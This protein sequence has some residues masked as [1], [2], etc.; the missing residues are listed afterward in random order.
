[1]KLHRH[2]IHHRVP[3]NIKSKY[4][5]AECRAGVSGSGV[6]V[7]ARVLATLLT[8]MD[9]ISSGN[10]DAE[11]SVI[12]MAATNRVDCIDA[13]LLRKGRFHQTLFVPPPNKDEREGLLLYF[14]LRCGLSAG[15][16]ASIRAS[17]GFNREGLSG[18]DVENIC[19][20]RFV[21]NINIATG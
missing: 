6:S 16:V 18:A 1:M 9:G 3:N 14:S 15:D 4:L 7:E 8:E 5:V 11:E 17:A 21:S 12:V 13:A 20:E 10:S 19:K 2:S